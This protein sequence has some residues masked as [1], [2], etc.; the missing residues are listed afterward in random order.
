MKTKIRMITNDPYND[1]KI[2]DTGYIEGF[3]YN[4]QQPLVAIVIGKRCTLCHFYDFEVIE[5]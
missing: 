4:G 3:C 1:W 2:N 5:E